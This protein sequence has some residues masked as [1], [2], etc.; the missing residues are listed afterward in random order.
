MG[1]EPGHHRERD[2][3]PGF[4]RAIDRLHDPLVGQAFLAGCP[5]HPAGLDTLRHVVELQRELVL[6]RDAPVVDGFGLAVAMR[7]PHLLTLVGEG[8]GDFDRGARQADAEAAVLVEA[9]TRGTVG[10]EAAREAQGEGNHLLDL[11]EARVAWRR[12]H[13]GKDL[14]RLFAGKEACRIQAIE[15]DV[16]QGTTT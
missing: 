6:R 11:A 7:H 16:G 15:P 3:L 4:G 8:V 12:E 13:A 2:G 14:D 10:Q 1:V 9:V 5:G